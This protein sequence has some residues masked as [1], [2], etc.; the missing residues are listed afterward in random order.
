MMIHEAAFSCRTKD[1]PCNTFS[2]HHATLSHCHLTLL[3]TLRTRA[4]KTDA[5]QTHSRS[6]KVMCPCKKEIET[7]EHMLLHYS[8]VT[9]PN[10]S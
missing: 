8:D 3:T 1:N 9:Q 5:Y 2:C 6:T 7:R 10:K 4:R